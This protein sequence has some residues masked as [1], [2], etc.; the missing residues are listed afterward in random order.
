MGIDTDKALEKRMAMILNQR[1]QSQEQVEAAHQQ[2]LQLSEAMVNYLQTASN[3]D[4]AARLRV[5]AEMRKSDQLLGMGGIKKHTGREVDIND[6]RVIAYKG[7]YKLAVLDIGLRSG[8]RVGM[9]VKIYRK[10]RHVGNALVVDVRDTLSG[11]IMQQFMSAGDQ[12]RVSD[13]V[14]PLTQDNSIDL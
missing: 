4:T 9:P 8:V 14:E 12:V 13:R 11:A 3:T 2:L 6:G 5:E 1:Q 7:D 10:D